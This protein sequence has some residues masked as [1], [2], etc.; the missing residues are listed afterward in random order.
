MVKPSTLGS[1]SNVAGS[2]N[3]T[4]MGAMYKRR[5]MEFS[6][7]PS[8]ESRSPCSTVFRALAAVAAMHIMNP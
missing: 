3:T 4:A 2:S 7:S 8:E 6:F 5:F 1:K